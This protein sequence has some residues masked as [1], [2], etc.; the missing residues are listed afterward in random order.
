MMKLPAIVVV[1]YNRP[2]ALSRLLNSIESADYNGRTDI[3]L[4][5]SVD[6]GGGKEIVEIAEL[7]EWRYGKKRIIVHDENLGLRKH[8]LSC[9]DLT[10]QYGAIILLEDDLYVSSEYYNYIE[11]AQQYYQNDEKIAG[12]SLYVYNH[13]DNA[14]ILFS[15]IKTEYDVFFMQVPS[16]SGQSWT[17]K[18]WG[19]FRE[20]LSSDPIINDNDLLPDQV[21]GWPNTSWK[22]YFFKYMVET[23]KY[24]VYPYMPFSTN[25]CDAG[26]HIQTYKN[27][28]QV[29]MEWRKRD[30]S[31]VD[32]SNAD[33][34][35]DAYYE[36]TPKCFF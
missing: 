8:I 14:Q 20:Y 3:P 22:K 28:L 4:V 32:F 19:L 2:N 1:T 31:F 7:F 5:I 6:G 35:Y 17:N 9:G 33:V 23:D 25:F 27:E 11:K 16:S 34:I 13:N 12:V 30:L 21:K 15:P 36:L 10:K 18:Q 29:P 26:I 24:F